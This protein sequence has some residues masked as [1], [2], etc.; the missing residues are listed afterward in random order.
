[1]VRITRRARARREHQVLKFGFLPFAA[2][3]STRQ[4]EP[5]RAPLSL[6]T[7]ERRLTSVQDLRFLLEHRLAQATM[8]RASGYN[9]DAERHALCHSDRQPHN[10]SGW[11][12]LMNPKSGGTSLG[13]WLKR[14]HPSVEVNFHFTVAENQPCGIVSLRE[15]C[16]RARSAFTHV[17]QVCISECEWEGIHVNATE[18]WPRSPTCARGLIPDTV[19]NRLTAVSDFDSFVAEL[20][21]H[22]NASVFSSNIVGRHLRRL[23]VLTIPQYVWISNS[24]TIVCTES[25]DQDLPRI[26]ASLGLSCPNRSIPHVSHGLYNILNGTNA[27]IKAEHRLEQDSK[28]CQTV[29]ELYDVDTALW[30]RHCTPRI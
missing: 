8:W 14:C 27:R 2:R 12:S 15:P 19:C 22:W 7:N 26:A 21:T 5:V 17:R 9:I 30:K 29:R 13:S 11:Q 16:A 23:N 25:M 10:N 24:S 4:M 3:S 6:S 20:R 28:A 18:A 1:M